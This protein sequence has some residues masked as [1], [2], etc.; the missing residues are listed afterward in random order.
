VRVATAALGLVLLASP[1][2]AGGRTEFSG[3]SPRVLFI[4]EVLPNNVGI[5]ADETGEFDPWIEIFNASSETVDL[6]GMFLSDIEELPQQ[7]E[8]PAGTSVCGG[9]WLLVWADGEPRQGALHSSFRLSP[10]AGTVG[11]YDADGAAVDLLSYESQGPD[12]SYGRL[13]DGDSVAM[14]FKRV[15]PLQPNMADVTLSLP[16]GLTAENGAFAIAEIVAVPANGLAYDITLEH[17]PAVLS[18]LGVQKTPLSAD[19]SLFFNVSNPGQVLIAMFGTEPLSG[20]GAILEVFYNVVGTAGEQTPLTFTQG[21]IN[22]GGISSDL[23]HGSFTVCDGADVDG[24]GVTLCEGDCN[25]QNDAQFPGNPEVCDGLDNNCDGTDD[26]GFLD[27]DGDTLADCVDPDDDGDGVPDVDDCDP[28]DPGVG[29]APAEVAAVVLHGGSP[30]QLS[31]TDQGGGSLYDVAGGMI[32]DV[33]QDQ[34]TDAAQ[35]LGNDE[36][37]ASFTDTRPDPTTWTGYYYI[38]RSQNDCGIGPYGEA[39]SGAPRLPVSDCP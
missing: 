9:C 35:C 15:T 32:A 2:N 31:W 20:S 28:L 27:T 10:F 33:V 39:T 4:N 26:E 3:D 13:P 18:G 17:D 24:D 5:N 25:D 12:R 6:G 36:G 22:E 8:I 7:W 37:S 29:A 1:A 11:L 30:T 21:D 23:V 16:I 14:G 19:H 34:N 38:V